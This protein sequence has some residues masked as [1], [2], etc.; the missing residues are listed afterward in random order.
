MNFLLGEDFRVFCVFDDTFIM[1]PLS[2]QFR[3][4]CCHHL[5]SSVIILKCYLAIADHWEAEIDDFVL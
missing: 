2:H 1:G 3:R 4:Y 5:K